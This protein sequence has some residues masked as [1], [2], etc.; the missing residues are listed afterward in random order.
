MQ[1][2]KK[3]DH[4]NDRRYRRPR[5]WRDLKAALGCEYAVMMFRRLERIADQPEAIG[6]PRDLLLI[7]VHHFSSLSG[8]Q[9]RLASDAFGLWSDTV[10]GKAATGHKTPPREAPP[11]E[12]LTDAER[13]SLEVSSSKPAVIDVCGTPYT[14]RLAVAIPAPA[15]GKSESVLVNHATREILIGVWLTEAER[16]MWLEAATEA[17]RRSV[18][19]QRAKREAEAAE[20]HDEDDDDWESEG[21]GWKGVA[22]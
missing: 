22:A 12:C 19:A 7:A 21:E 4:D 16:A 13:V 10:N 6:A 1:K 20:Q 18:L 2:H 8:E 5:G 11:A 9:R 14:V 3:L 17:A 15:A